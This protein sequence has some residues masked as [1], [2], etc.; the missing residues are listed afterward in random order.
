M[1]NTTEA[2][3]VTL[4]LSPA[5]YKIIEEC[6][7]LDEYPSVEDWIIDSLA[8]DLRWFAGQHEGPVDFTNKDINQI[9]E[10]KE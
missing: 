6:A 5:L 2:M 3:K 10:S 1:T 7:K 9:F 4:T 8:P